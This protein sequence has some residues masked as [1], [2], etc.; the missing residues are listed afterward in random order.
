MYT[1]PDVVPHGQVGRMGILEQMVAGWA[2]DTH[3]QVEGAED[4]HKLEAVGESNKVQRL[5]QHTGLFS[6]F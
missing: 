5:H 2:E 4:I 6:F 1:V 3:Y